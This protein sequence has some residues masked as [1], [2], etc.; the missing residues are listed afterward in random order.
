VESS[1]GCWAAGLPFSLDEIWV[2]SVAEKLTCANVLA[3]VDPISV[4]SFAFIVAD[5]ETVSDDEILVLSFALTSVSITRDEVSD[6]LIAVE[7]DPEISAPPEISILED[8]EDPRIVVSEPGKSVVVYDASVELI[9]VESVPVKLTWPNDVDSLDEISVVSLDDLSTAAND[10]VSVEEISVLSEAALATVPKA[11]VSLEEIWVVS[12]LVKFTD[13][14]EEA[15]DAPRSVLSVPLTATTILWV[16]SD[17]PISVLSVALT[18]IPPP[19]WILE[20]SNE[21]ICVVSPPGKSVVV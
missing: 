21:S 8:S 4:L 16:V 9:S 14:K 5:T 15:S 17:D 7:S 2:V 12:V 18:L 6:E 19:T 3:S 13:P 10:E 1:P 11:L 20:V